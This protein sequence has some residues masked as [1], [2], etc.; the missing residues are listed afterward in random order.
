MRV[1]NCICL[2]I[3]SVIAVASQ[4]EI[5]TFDELILPPESYWNGSDG[6]GGFT[7]AGLGF[8]NLYSDIYKYWEGFSYSNITD[9]T[10]QGM[11]SQYNAITGTGQ[12][13]SPN[14]AI[15]YVGWTEPPTITLDTAGTVYGLYVTN[16]NMAYY[17]MLNDST[18][19]FGGTTGNDPDWFLL[20]IT[21]KDAD[22][23]VTGM[24]DFYLADYRFDDNSMDYIIDEWEY[25]D[26]TPLGQVKTLEFSLSSSDTGDFGMNT[27]AYFAL[28]TII[29]QPESTDTASYNDAGINGYINPYDGWKHSSPQDPN[30][31]INPIFRGWATE[32]VNY[33]QTPGVD[34][35]W[36]EPNKTLGAATGNVNDIFSLGDLSR[37]QIAQGE[38]VGWVIVTFDEPIRNN[39]G[40][41]F[42]VFEN[43]LLSDF[44]TQ[45][46]S[47]AGE[48]LAELA[49]VEASSNGEDFVRFP[50][51]S[52]TEQPG[53]LFS[54][55]EMNNVYNLAGKHPNAYNIC[56]GTP[57]DLQEL[58]NHS[59][60]TS[61]LVDI[62]DI[63]YIRLVDIPGTGD[64]YDDAVT[65]INPNTW[66]AWDYYSDNHPIFDAWNTSLVPLYPSG[67]FDSEAIGTLEEQEYSADINL[68]G[69]VDESD[70]DLFL[71]AW[72]SHL[73]Q[74]NWIARCDLAEPKNYA[75]DGQDLDVFLLQWLK[76][77]KWRY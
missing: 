24:V 51:L 65:Y 60:V 50:S 42:A 62:N 29:F 15:C 19:K 17:P 72:Q 3:V 77:E 53:D 68:D 76:V 6:L 38:S 73:G 67:G 41:D 8:N 39:R 69:I 5:A 30:A 9:T 16:N 33:N 10:T 14:Y 20:T 44:T 21:G 71:S 46:G 55:I 4:A 54:T 25:I 45:E 43:G 28:D 23:V 34:S 37:E 26:L 7:S 64:F 1:R 57:F 70:L 49:Y 11:P 13:G 18:A 61:G 2:I 59:M 35:R 27:P 31:V 12:G 32:V 58:A 22:G 36:S 74:I 75:I 56:T 40:Y 63:K 48:I 66:P 52:L 47:A